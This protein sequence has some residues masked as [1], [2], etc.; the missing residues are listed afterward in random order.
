M[1]EIMWFFLFCI[2]RILINI[3]FSRSNHI[4]TKRVFCIFYDKIVSTVYKHHIFFFCSPVI[5]H[6]GGFHIL[7]IWIMVQS[8]Y[9]VDIFPFE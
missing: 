8:P 4:A 7:T 5:G 2:L 6:I 3:M 1:R 9:H